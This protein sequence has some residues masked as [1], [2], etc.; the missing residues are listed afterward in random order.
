[1]RSLVGSFWRMRP[2]YDIMRAIMRL[3]MLLFGT[4]VLLQNVKN[5]Y[6]V[7]QLHEIEGHH[8]DHTMVAVE[9]FVNG[10]LILNSKSH[11]DLI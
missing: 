10:H 7:F 1:M 11:C 3:K 4:F 2:L 8:C 5:S 6:F 9:K